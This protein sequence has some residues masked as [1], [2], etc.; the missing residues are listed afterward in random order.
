MCNLV[1]DR[2]EEM[3]EKRVSM[4]ARLKMSEKEKDGLQV[5]LSIW[6]G[7]VRCS[8]SSMHTPARM[9]SALAAGAAGAAGGGAALSGWAHA[10][11]LARACDG[12]MVCVLV[13]VLCHAAGQGGGGP[14]V[15]GQAGGDAAQPH[16]RHT[17][18]RH[19]DWGGSPHNTGCSAMCIVRCLYP[20]H[21]EHLV[22]RAPYD[23]RSRKQR[24]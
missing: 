21:V 5:R 1:S 17:H 23:C 3:N 8:L 2:L 16:P 14:D 19:E 13:L 15:P 24:P 22:V 9:A 10:T 20:A 6:S 4:V 11:P 12:D 7:D 18:L